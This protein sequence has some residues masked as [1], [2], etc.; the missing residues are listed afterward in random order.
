MRTLTILGAV[1]LGVI[2]GGFVCV[3]LVLSSCEN[4]AQRSFDRATQTFKFDTASPT[5]SHSIS[6]D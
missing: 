1:F 4:A 3:W 2:G 6:N 5:P